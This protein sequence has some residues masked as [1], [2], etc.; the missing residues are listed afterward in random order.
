MRGHPTQP[1]DSCFRLGLIWLAFS[2]TAPA[3]TVAQPSISAENDAILDQVYAEAQILSAALVDGDFPLLMEKIHPSVAIFM[4]G[5]EGAIEAFD[6]NR[7]DNLANGIRTTAVVP[8]RATTVHRSEEAI[9]VVTPYTMT[10]ES[11]DQVQTTESYFI[12][13]RVPDSED[14]VYVDALVMPSEEK[15]RWLFPSLPE[16]VDL[17][18]IQNQVR[19]K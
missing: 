15:T 16:D 8:V 5:K 12:Q 9:L 11:Q 13:A 3:A 4:G 7:R 19:S 2:L 14:W 18:Q 1:G 6:S 17:P 10:V